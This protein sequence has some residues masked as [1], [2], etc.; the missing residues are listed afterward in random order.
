MYHDF[1][2]PLV[3]CLAVLNT[4]A[5]KPPYTLQAIMDNSEA[6]VQNSRQTSPLKVP[7]SPAPAPALR[8]TSP[9]EAPESPAP[10]QG[11]RQTS[12]P[13]VPETSSTRK[14]RIGH[15]DRI[16]I[17][18]LRSIGWT[19]EAI[20]AYMGCTQRQVQYT[21]RELKTTPKKHTG[22][23][24]SIPQWVIDR[25]ID[26]VKE[27]KPGRQLAWSR[28]ARH[29]GVDHLVSTRQVYGILRRAGFSRP[30]SRQK[31]PVS[32]QADAL[33][34]LTPRAGFSDFPRPALPV[35]ESKEAD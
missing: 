3:I 18:T 32:E 33:A 30:G 9:S 6:S 28:I 34:P 21:V 1:M 5:S 25:I 2:H 24:T 31:P 8:Q 7:E 35:P 16:R 10:A 12:V 20:A 11:S 17:T 29:L 22:R 15:D 14:L 19:Y 26:F 23:P 27:S 13:K 4:H